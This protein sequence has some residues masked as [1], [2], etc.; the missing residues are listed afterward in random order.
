MGGCLHI[1][2]PL[3]S[4]I[5]VLCKQEKILFLNKLVLQ[6][7]ILFM[8]EMGNVDIT[9]ITMQTEIFCLLAG[10]GLFAGMFTMFQENFGQ[11]NMLS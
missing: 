3:H 5:F 4:S 7:S 10:R 2:Q 8:V 11:L 6:D 1:G 9:L